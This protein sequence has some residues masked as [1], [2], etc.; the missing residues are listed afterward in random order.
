M[1]RQRA[2][3]ADKQVGVEEFR[4]CPV[5]LLLRQAAHLRQQERPQARAAVDV[6]VE[7]PVPQEHLAA[8]LQEH[9]VAVP[10]ERWPAVEVH[11]VRLHPTRSRS[12]G[13]S[14]IPVRRWRL[15]T[16]FIRS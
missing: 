3:V 1:C 14:W 5:L 16:A 12:S 9:P 6:G 15:N 2:V 8:V 4:A 10:Q 13:R 11:A 7:R